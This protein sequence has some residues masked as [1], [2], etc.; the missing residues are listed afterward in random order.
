MTTIDDLA[1][2]IQHRHDL[3]T[4]DAARESVTATIDQ[5]ADDP[6]L[7]DADAAVLTPEGVKLVSEAIAESYKVGA[8]ATGAQI[9]LA[10]IDDIATEIAKLEDR[11]TEL[12]TRRDELVRA[13]L[14]TELPRA[15]IAAA[16]RVKPARLYQI[17]DG[18]R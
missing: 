10:D 2:T 13:A 1:R 3:D 17:R 14:R 16:A 9:L 15:D 6:D 7:W 11:H 5:I 8:V 18:R 4:I 12:V